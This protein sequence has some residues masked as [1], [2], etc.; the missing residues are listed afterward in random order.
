MGTRKRLKQSLEQLYPSS[1]QRLYGDMTTLIRRKLWLQII[2]GMFLGILIGVLLGPSMGWVSPK[3]AGI[4]GEWI[5]L[6][7]YFFLGVIQMII[8]PLVFASVVRGLAANENMDQ[9]RQTGLKLVV[10]FLLTTILAVVLGIT[11]GQLVKPGSFINISGIEGMEADI[12]VSDTETARPGDGSLLRQIP[13]NLVSVLPSNP[14]SAMTNSEMLQVVIFAFAFGLALVSMPARSAKPMLDFLGALEG[15]C[16]NIVRWVMLIVP[17]AVL[18]LIAKVVL[19]TGI[20]VIQSLGI[21]VLTVLLGFFLL[22]VLY[23]LIVAT[24]GGRNPFTFLSHIREAMI[25][26]FSTNSSAATMPTSLK[27]AEE[28]LK[29]RPSLARFVVP[30]GATVNMGASAL[31]QGLATIFI[32]QLYNIDLALPAL[33]SLVMTAVGASIGTP[34]TPGVGIIVLSSVLVS[35]GIPL[36]GLTLL[37]GIDRILELFRASLN[38]TGDLVACTVMEKTVKVSVD[39]DTEQEKQHQAEI[40]REATGEDTIV[41]EEEAS[42]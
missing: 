22:L 9:L 2:I 32:A 37:I 4:I 5:A 14:L 11:V 10:Y 28:N 20:A 26:A 6:P 25:M 27:V 12:D 15:I 42:A 41:R 1:L 18:G 24:L 33:V 19:Q 30:V 23:L 40:Q 31:Y 13:E 34:A 21:Y 17:L 39:R 35:A 3:V 16:M 8:V 38:V 36:E 7:G 29:I